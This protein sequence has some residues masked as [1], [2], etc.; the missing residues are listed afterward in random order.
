M[1]KISADEQQYIE[2]QHHKVKIEPGE[3]AVAMISDYINLALQGM[4]V[5]LDGDIPKQQE[6]LGITIVDSDDVIRLF[7]AAPEQAAQ[8]QGFYIFR[9]NQPAAFIGN[10]RI[11]Q[12]MIKLDF[13]DFAAGKL[14]EKARKITI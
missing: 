14:Y 8:L 9:N 13:M 4:G 11:H 10:S 6:E 7:G 3:Y 1:N 5:D 2:D 12:G